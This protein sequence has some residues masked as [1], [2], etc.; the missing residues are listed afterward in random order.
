MVR[1]IV[2]SQMTNR[3]ESNFG[4]DELEELGNMFMDGDDIDGD[5]LREAEEKVAKREEYIREQ[6]E[7]TESRLNRKLDLSAPVEA[8]ITPL[9]QEFLSQ[10]EGVYLDEEQEESITN[11]LLED[12]TPEVVQEQP[13]DPMQQLADRIG[14]VSSRTH[15]TEY[16]ADAGNKFTALD[17]EPMA[18]M[19]AKVKDI[20]SQLGTIVY[21]LGA[22]SP[23]TG[24]VLLRELDD[25]NFGS[26]P[27]EVG[28][29]LTWGQDP[30]TG[31]TG[32]MPSTGLSINL[33]ESTGYIPDGAVLTF[34][35]PTSTWKPGLYLDDIENVSVDPPA[36]L[37]DGAILSY[38]LAS[39]TWK[40]NA[41]LKDIYDVHYDIPEKPNGILWYD[42][43]YDNNIGS[44]RDNAVLEALSDVDLTGL[45]E[46]QM[47]HWDAIGG[48]WVAG[49]SL[50]N[51]DDVTVPLGFATDGSILSYDKTA[52]VWNPGANLYGLD[53]VENHHVHV[54]NRFDTYI[55]STGSG[56]PTGPGEF[57]YNGNNIILSAIMSNGE[58][59]FPDAGVGT[60]LV[61]TIIRIDGTVAHITGNGNW[62]VSTDRNYFF[63]TINE[64]PA[65]IFANVT[66]T[67]VFEFIAIH[68]NRDT[69][70]LIYEDETSTWRPN[71]QDELSIHLDDL[72]DVQ[73]STTTVKNVTHEFDYVS[74][75][76][77]LKNGGLFTYVETGSGASYT[78]TVKFS[79][80][81]KNGR[82]FD[83]SKYGQF[84]EVPTNNILFRAGGYED[85]LQIVD[86]NNTWEEYSDGSST[87]YEKEHY[88]IQTVPGSNLTPSGYH[89]LSRAKVLQI[90]EE[91]QVGPASIIAYD[92]A[93][94]QWL[95]VRNSI[96]NS[97]DV[98]LVNY[99][100]VHRY[101]DMRMPT[102]ELSALGQFSVTGSTR[103]TL[104]LSVVDLDGNPTGFDPAFPV[105]LNS[106]ANDTHIYVRFRKT[107][108]STVDVR[109]NVIY[110][111][112]YNDTS[113]T[114]TNSSNGEYVTRVINGTREGN[115]NLM[116][117][118]P[119]YPAVSS[120]PTTIAV[121]M[122]IIEIIPNQNNNILSYDASSDTWVSRRPSELGI[123]VDDIAET[124]SNHPIVQ[125]TWNAREDNINDSASVN[126]EFD[127]AYANGTNLFWLGGRNS[128]SNVAVF[129]F[130]KTD[131][132]GNRFDVDEYGGVGNP[133]N[134]P[135]Q[136]YYG[137]NNYT[138]PPTNN[139]W[140]ETE[141]YFE[142]SGT[143]GLF[144]TIPNN[145]TVPKASSAI[146][147]IKN[148]S[149]TDGSVVKLD[150]KQVAG[151]WISKENVVSGLS[152]VDVLTSN[153]VVQTYSTNVGTNLPTNP[154]EYGYDD[155]T[156]TFRISV[157]GDDPEDGAFDIGPY[158]RTHSP[159]GNDT[160]GQLNYMK[161]RIDGQIVRVSGNST[162][163]WTSISN[164]SAWEV[165]IVENLS[166]II[167]N[168][169][170][171]EIL[172]IDGNGDE[173]HLIYNQETRQWNTAEITFNIA[174]AEDAALTR[175]TNELRFNR[176]VRD[177][178]NADPVANG[179]FTLAT[180][181]NTNVT[182]LKF[183]KFDSNGNEFLIHN[184]EAVGTN[185]L[186]P[187]HLISDG[188]NRF[189]LTVANPPQAWVDGTTY[190]QIDLEPADVANL[191]NSQILDFVGSLDLEHN[192]IP[193]WD[194][195]TRSFN[196]GARMENLKNFSP[197][198]FETL[199]DYST[200]VDAA[201]P[202]VPQTPGEYSYVASAGGGSLL[203][204]A[205]SDSTAA[206]FTFGDFPEWGSVGNNI[207]SLIVEFGGTYTEL[208]SVT[209]QTVPWTDSGSGYWEVSVDQDLSTIVTDNV[210][211]LRIVFFHILHDGDIIRYDAEL[212]QWVSS[213]PA[214]QQAVGLND[215]NDVVA[216][217]PGYLDVFQYNRAPTNTTAVNL[218]AGQFISDP[219]KTDANGTDP[220]GNTPTQPDGTVGV[221]F[222]NVYFHPID[223]N[224]RVFD[225]SYFGGGGEVSQNVILLKQG[226][227]IPVTD[228]TGY[229]VS[230]PTNNSG[231][232]PWQ[233]FNVSDN[234]LDGWLTTF[235]GSNLDVTTP[236]IGLSV[237]RNLQ[238]NNII[239]YDSTS[240]TWFADSNTVDKIDDV[241]ADPETNVESSVLLYSTVEDQWE[242]KENTLANVSDVYTENI[243]RHNRF[244]VRSTTFDPSTYDSNVPAT[245]LQQGEWYIDLP[246]SYLYFAPSDTDG[247]AFAITEYR[248]LNLLRPDVVIEYD[249]GPKDL[250]FPISSDVDWDIYTDNS[251][252]EVLYR[253]KVKENLRSLFT[254]SE[255]GLTSDN[256]SDGDNIYLSRVS[257][258]TTSGNTLIYNTTQDLWTPGRPSINQL[259]D[260]S[261]GNLSNLTDD[262][263]IRWD[264]TNDRWVA[265]QF[266]E[267]LSSTPTGWVST[268]TE[269]PMFVGSDYDFA[270]YQISKV[271]RMIHWSLHMKMKSTVPASS[272]VTD[273]AIKLMSN[274]DSTV[275]APLKSGSTDIKYPATIGYYNQ[276]DT[277][278]DKSVSFNVY[279]SFEAGIVHIYLNGGTL[280]GNLAPFSRNNIQGNTEIHVSGSYMAAARW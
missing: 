164:N 190:W 173:P 119:A 279:A 30:D 79:K 17:L 77:N 251:N 169:S 216:S 13:V 134:Q 191:G 181:P 23:G 99:R 278:D 143:A 60:P 138:I 116:N 127:T 182:T 67:S 187:D 59:F 74:T 91:S 206:T 32:W 150:T 246:N 21:N 114:W 24:V 222:E 27:P 78:L 152:D 256:S 137:V 245:H 113:E 124:D 70:I 212:D 53:N 205:Y 180:D 111:L 204:I 82:P 192:D 45:S 238:D 54:L 106:D 41:Y 133:L 155:T 226:S 107:T 193:Y 69:D 239:R 273:V 198:H 36:G 156:N 224:G 262:H 158:S 100:V 63:I 168:N 170:I 227:Y 172:D 66:P 3:F 272:S 71:G 9:Q 73:A 86:P 29:V 228:S 115:L 186:V 195:Y 196:P 268:A 269:S 108:D 39:D 184:Y 145:T 128:S 48:N 142:I 188:T 52:G 265:S 92:E 46:G 11:Q 208:T 28:E 146:S 101:G 112:D 132:N 255:G 242:A 34:D 249:S 259:D 47:M 97:D 260:F 14:V 215:L 280:L 22:G 125:Y 50:D 233:T 64:D 136:L 120:G 81:D 1:R 219:L 16:N 167:T 266:R 274:I 95:P 126:T 263:V 19:E 151:G 98:Q 25:V 49:A 253:I 122:D 261:T 210:T 199:Y 110:R 252:A 166:T 275:W 214:E 117:V 165:G 38:D 153:E 2:F 202:A 131:A 270:Y 177:N 221:V 257:K 130:T 154:G 185:I 218:T 189:P 62:D 89:P 139:V 241:S 229:S 201:T 6:N 140:I 207:T 230:W 223:A 68:Q 40:P 174:D 8:E 254:K 26:T 80:V 243:T 20:Q 209:D 244:N 183:F 149:G 162:T 103:N 61:S 109:E 87:S 5:I 175:G 90:L 105:Y 197:N 235:I 161:L 141:T 200:Y 75:D 94:D 33:P 163:I 44:W 144:S 135:L 211:P 271:N 4:M 148:P 10:M 76:D 264:N 56:V 232:R 35:L 248:N 42:S 179:R 72:D 250:R 237:V 57:S 96:S 203:R 267:D 194:D 121:E 240:E 247:N 234:S 123:T 31:Q 160:T 176:Y 15:L 276:F 118:F 85:T 12:N 84:G 225:P 231:P 129:R 88:S 18:I 37:L 157:V 217:N 147:V 236:T 51:L 7:Y 43:K 102:Y 213:D 65:V 104:V 220:D 83:V 93:A 258:P 58:P 55:D 171:I 277:M 159:S 178:I